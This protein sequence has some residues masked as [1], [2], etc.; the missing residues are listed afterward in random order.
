MDSH[1]ARETSTVAD[2]CLPW[3]ETSESAFAVDREFIDSFPS[4]NL[5]ILQDCY[6]KDFA[7]V[8]AEI[9]FEPPPLT[10][11]SES[12]AASSRHLAYFDLHD[13]AA[14]KVFFGEA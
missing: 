4:T 12:V 9:N 2:T 10:L 1:A 14:R 8:S 6:D 3:H 11:Y 13:D 7:A 5:K